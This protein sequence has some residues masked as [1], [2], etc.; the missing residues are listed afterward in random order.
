MGA[1]PVGKPHYWDL[2]CAELAAADPVMARLIA[3]LG[4]S[5][6]VARGDSFVTLARAIVG[7]QISVRAAQTVWDRFVKAARDVRPAR[8]AR[9]RE[10]TLRAC[11]LSQRKAEYVRDLAASFAGGTIDPLALPE[12]DDEAVIGQLVAVRGVGR[13]TAEMFLIFNLLR[14]DVF[15]VDDLGLLR[16]IARHYRDGAQVSRGEALAIGE[17]WRPWRSVATWIM[18]RSLDPVP[19]EY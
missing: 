17:S 8:V 18:W 6:L 4:A 11:G 10:S 12:L 5:H 9:M 3:T 16:A 15:P 1:A 7:Q 14:P 13:W 19:V 2:A